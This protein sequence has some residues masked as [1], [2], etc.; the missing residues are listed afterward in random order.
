MPLPLYLLRI[1]RGEGEQGGH[2]KHHLVALKLGIIGMLAAAVTLHIQAP[3]E[4]GETLQ[5]H[6]LT[7]DF[8]ELVKLRASG[9]VAKKLILMGL[10]LF[11]V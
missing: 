11:G 6:L 10:A 1:G 8:Q 4:T 7:Q 2:M 3:S 5:C 9:F